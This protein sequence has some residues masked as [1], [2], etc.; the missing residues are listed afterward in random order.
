VSGEGKLALDRFE[1]LVQQFT[2]FP[3]RLVHDRL[4]VEVEKVECEH[5]HLDLDIL[6]LDILLLARHELLEREHFLLLDIPRNRLTVENK[7]LGVLVD[8][9][10]QLLKDVRVF[11]GQIF[12]IPREDSRHALAD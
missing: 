4:A 12:R 11:L 7:T 1:R 5:A 9:S 6:S 10:R 3:E 2:T 8:P